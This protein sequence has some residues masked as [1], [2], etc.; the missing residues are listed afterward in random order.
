MEEEHLSWRHALA[1]ITTVTAAL[2]IWNGTHLVLTEPERSSSGSSMHVSL[3]QPPAPPAPP[4]QIP[5]PPKPIASKQPA[6]RA[7]IV[8]SQ[9]A[10]GPPVIADAAIA[11]ENSTSSPPGQPTPSA[12]PVANVS[13]ESTYFASVLAAVEQQKRYPMTKDARLQHPR[14]TVI[15]LLV[16]DRSGKLLD[17]SIAQSAGSILDRQALETV[18]RASYPPF[19]ATVWPSETQHRFEVSVYFIPP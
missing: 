6:S 13:L 12:G 8:P 3:A 1:L 18:Q 19:P 9:H 5:K 14:G 11:S 4:K 15:V 17:S 2:L 10:V 16:L 7:P